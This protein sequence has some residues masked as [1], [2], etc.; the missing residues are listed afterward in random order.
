MV[1]A[2]GEERKR[3]EIGRGRG[4]EERGERRGEREEG[5]VVEKG[6]EGIL[7]VF[8]F[9]V[10]LTASTSG[11]FVFFGFVSFL[12]D[13]PKLTREFQQLTRGVRP[14]LMSTAANHSANKRKNRYHN[15]LPFDD[16]RVSLSVQSA[17]AG[18]D[19]INASFIDGYRKK[20]AFIATQAPLPATF[21]DFWRMLWEHGC[22]TLVTLAQ[23]V[24]NDKVIFKR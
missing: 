17:V 21:S 8:Q 15:T 23:E 10:I 18:S 2:V 5:R 3:G 11:Q 1:N 19:Y 14:R 24:E 13:E 9:I 4:R 7:T 12:L 16:T 20:K 22:C 6:G